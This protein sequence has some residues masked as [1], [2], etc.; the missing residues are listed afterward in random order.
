MPSFAR[1]RCLQQSDQ[2]SHD[3]V[4]CAQ[5]IDNRAKSLFE[6]KPLVCEGEA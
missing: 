6:P 3:Q 1:L 5:D 2:L 4:S